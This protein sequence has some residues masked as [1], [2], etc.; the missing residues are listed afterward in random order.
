MKYQTRK[1][2]P[3]RMKKCQ[4]FIA[5]ASDFILLF[6]QM[7]IYD[8]MKDGKVLFVLHCNCIILSHF[9]RD[10]YCVYAFLFMIFIILSLNL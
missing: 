8:I 1:D 5:S 4:Y 3:A 6:F 7:K 2:P 10:K 9:P